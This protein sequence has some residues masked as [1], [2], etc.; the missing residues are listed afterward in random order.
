MHVDP[1]F[2]GLAVPNFEEPKWRPVK[3]VDGTSVVDP[4]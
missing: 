1:Y 4:D 2:L 3:E